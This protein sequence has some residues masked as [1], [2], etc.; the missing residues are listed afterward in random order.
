[1]NHNFLNFL[2]TLQN[3]EKT[4][5]FNVFKDY[6]LIE[7]SK[8]WNEI[9]SKFSLLS[10]IRFSVI[11]T[12]A[13]GSTSHYLAHLLS[14]KENTVGVYTSPHLISPKERLLILNNPKNDSDIEEFFSNTFSKY[15]DS[16]KHLSY[17]EFLT[18]FTYF[19]FQSKSTKFEIWEAG[20]GG[21]LDA[22][23]LVQAEII[24]LTKIGL[25][26]SEILGESK[27]KICIEKLGIIGSNTKF[28]F[29]MDQ[30]DPQLN[31]LIQTIVSKHKIPFKMIQS[32]LEEEDNSYLHKNFKF[33]KSIMEQLIDEKYLLPTDLN[34]RP[35][36]ELPKPKGRMEILS[37]NPHIV[38]DPAHNPDA[39][40]YSLNEIFG[41]E[42][43][44]HLI[45]GSL[46]D[47]DRQGILDEIQKFP[48]LSVCFFEGDGFGTFPS[49][50]LPFPTQTAKTTTDLQGYL[51][52]KNEAILVLG[53]FRLYQIVSKVLQITT[54]M[55]N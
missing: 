5:N 37:K 45:L 28:V 8:T 14:S 15:L 32:E 42:N 35:F 10:P 53:S 33:A 34:K 7:L 6:S 1:M 29:A 17:F 52:S 46:R 55:E 50:A 25:D 21:R 41:R 24:V 39:I 13:K 40:R 12:N 51:E 4:R 19:Y 30:K 31:E 26:H 36:T 20:L 48:L 23:K 11:G 2:D 27:E 44:I 9:S 16:V 47:K 3:V 38:F 22:T 43:R 49:C 54:K 18:V